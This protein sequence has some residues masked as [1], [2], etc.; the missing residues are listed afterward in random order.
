MILEIFLRKNPKFSKLKELKDLGF[1]NAFYCSDLEISDQQNIFFFSLLALEF[2]WNVRQKGAPKPTRFT[3][4]MFF[5]CTLVLSIPPK[6]FF[7]C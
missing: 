4:K 3:D 1:T 5:Y 2:R 6:V 7:R